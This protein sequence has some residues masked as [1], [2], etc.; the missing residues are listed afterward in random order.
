MGKTMRVLEII[1]V[2]P[3]ERDGSRVFGRHWPSSLPIL[4]PFVSGRNR[5]VSQYIVSTIFYLFG[6][7]GRRVHATMI[8]L[9]TRA[10]RINV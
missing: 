10:K 8:T 2:G 1:H 9:V 3:L 6:A 7:V 4:P 5:V